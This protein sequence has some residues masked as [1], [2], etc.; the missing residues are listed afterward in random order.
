MRRQPTIP[1]L[2]FRRRHQVFRSGKS[3]PVPDAYRS[4][5]ARWLLRLLG[6]SRVETDKREVPH[7]LET[8]GLT[9]LQVKNLRHPTAIHAF[10][11][12]LAE[13]E[14]QPLGRTGAL[15]QN[16]DHISDMI[17][18]SDL[19]KETLAFV[20]L[21]PT[22][23]VLGDC[24]EG[25]SEQTA[26]TV[27][28]L[29][30]LALGVEQTDMRAVLRNESPLCAAGLLTVD[31][32]ETGMSDM[33][34][35][36]NGLD[37]AVLDEPTDGH[38]LLRQYF[39]PASPPQHPIAAFPHLKNDLGVLRRILLAARH[40]ETQGINILIHG[41]SGTSK[42]AWVHALAASV[43]APLF[44]VSHETDETDLKEQHFRF[45]SYLLS[46]KVLAKN[47]GSLILFDE[48]EDLFPDRVARCLEGLRVR[49]NIRPGPIPCWN[50]TLVRPSGVAMR[51]NRST[52]HS[53]VDS[54]T[55]SRSYHHLDR[56][57][58]RC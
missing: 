57:G 30:A 19:E 48:I 47:C 35:L 23:S 45:R 6:T 22:C 31:R 5:V 25:L 27:C 53:A 3:K 54:P 32:T 20:V 40:Q 17:G 58:V 49:D 13:L 43:K 16:I 46:Q 7:I 26:A 52:R 29:L 38:H 10:R 24:L 4:Q 39:R 9:H 2:S 41:T 44:E 12:R 33:L 1:S 56:S 36:L 11:T 15:Y 28:D 50:Q 34:S 18:L 8:V 14:R 55:C 21:F 51:F 42:T 37:T